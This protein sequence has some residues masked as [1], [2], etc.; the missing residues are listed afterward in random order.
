MFTNHS[1]TIQQIKQPLQQQ[2]PQLILP[3]VQNPL[4][5]QIPPHI[6]A[7]SS[8]QSRINELIIDTNYDSNSVARARKL[9]LITDRLYKHFNDK[10]P[11]SIKSC[12]LTP[13]TIKLI[14]D[15]GFKKYG[16]L[17]HPAIS[18]I[19]DIIDLK[20]KQSIHSDNRS[21]VQY[22]TTTQFSM[23]E[24]AKITMDK[25]LENYT[26]KVTVL[27]NSDKA[28]EAQLP[29]KMAPL[30]DMIKITEIDPFSEDFPLKD[31]EK[32]TDMLV[33]EVRRF[34]YYLAIDS[35][36]RNIQQSTAPN[37]FIIELAP[38]TPSRENAHNNNKGYIDRSFGNIE[39]CELLSVIIRDT[40]DQPD[41]SDSG[42]VYF[43]YLLLQFDE[44]QQNYFGTNNDLTRT[45][46]I[47]TEYRQP[48]GSK[49]KYYRMAGDH[50]E[51]TVIKIYNPRINISRI[52]TRLLLP[53]GTL[54]NF[55]SAFND[56]TS[57]TVIS[58]SFRVSTIQRNL[59]T[60]YLDKATH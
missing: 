50:A 57:N 6:A 38:A 49:Y 2:I 15:R 17:N 25:Y 14:V 5:Q 24:K 29:A 51:S 52:T 11:T 47:L 28:V 7:A 10:Y 19:I 12:G 31:R 48:T 54:F 8:N 53:D 46:A 42:S 60:Q 27:N 45:F 33:P 9:D 23:D 20:L 1:R 37:N 44:L 34:D 3:P 32:Q 40:S 58:V 26:S 35:K 30:N 13:A 39:S 21:N 4:L 16:N 55:G 59:A 56:D 22:D 41:S 36:D 43:P 18:S